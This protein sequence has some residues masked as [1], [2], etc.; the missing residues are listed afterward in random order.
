MQQRLKSDQTRQLIIQRAFEL[1]YKN[2][3]RTT[4]IDKVMNATE[5]T[6]GAFYHHFK[7]KRELGLAVISQEIQKRI[8][9][10]MI[11]PLY[12]EK[13]PVQNLLTVFSNRLRTFTTDEKQSGCPANNLINEIGDTEEAYQLALRRIIEEW[14]AALVSVIEKGKQIGEIAPIADSSAIAIYLISSFEGV[15]GIRKL[16]SDDHILED[17]LKAL[18]NYIKRLR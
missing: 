11:S 14:K 12:E 5:L 1:F 6:K 13:D 18:E 7:S 8:Y 4:S 3:F 10:G 16:Y 2:G 15:R 9:T 17:Y